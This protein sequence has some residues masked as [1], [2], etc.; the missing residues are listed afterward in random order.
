MIPNFTEST[1][2]VPLVIN[3]IN[4]KSSDDFNADDWVELYNPNTFSV[5]IS[6]WKLKDDD[7]SHVYYIPDGTVISAD[8]YLILVK[9]ASDFSDV[10]RLSGIFRP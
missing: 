7:N 8:G 10:F 1:T 4:F 2:E 5:D 3:E 6:S 9:D